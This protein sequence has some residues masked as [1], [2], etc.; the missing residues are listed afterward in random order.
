MTGH[1]MWT[2]NCR[3][4]GLPLKD[5]LSQELQIGPICRGGKDYTKEARNAPAHHRER[6]NKLIAEACTTC[7]L[8]RAVMLIQELHLIGFPHT[9][10]AIS[11]RIA[12]VRIEEHGDVLVMRAPY[13]PEAAWGMLGRWDRR[14]RAWEFPVEKRPQI[15]QNLKKHFKNRLGVGPKGLFYIGSES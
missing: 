8:E 5:A 15:W 7:D 13:K 3:V 6:A 10:R 1:E 4:C 14:Q 12:H 11:K 2:S 9:Q